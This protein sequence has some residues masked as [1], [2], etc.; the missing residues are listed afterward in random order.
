MR[1]LISILVGF[2]MSFAVLLPMQLGVK[3]AKAE[4]TATPIDM[5]LLA[6]GSNALGE[7]VHNDELTETYENVG[8]ATGATAFA[9]FKWSVQAGYG[10]TDTQVGPEYGMAQALNENG[11][12]SF[13][14]KSAASGSS[15]YDMNDKGN[16]FPR[17]IWDAGHDPITDN[18]T[19]GYEY[20]TF[21][22]GFETVYN[23]LVDNGYAPEVKGMVWMQGE[24]DLAMPKLYEELMKIFITDVRE[25]LTKITG[26]E[27]LT[28]MPFIIGKLPAAE[29]DVAAVA[30]NEMQDRVVAAMEKVFTVETADL[31]STSSAQ[32]FDAKG[33]ETLG[34]RFGEKVWEYAKRSHVTVEAENGSVS[35]D[36]DE[37]NLI[38]TLTPDKNNK[39][40]SLVINGVDRTADVV[41]DQLI[42]KNEG[43]N[44]Q[45][46][47]T[48]VE[49]AKYYV[50][51]DNIGEY[52]AT[53][54]SKAQYC[55]EGKVLKVKIEIPEEYEILSVKFNDTEMEYNEASGCYE[56]IP[57]AHGHV[58]VSVQEPVANDSTEAEAYGGHFV[59][60]EGETSS[61]NP[62]VSSISIS[63][64]ALLTLAGAA[65]AVFKR[66]H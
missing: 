4:E 12:Q 9:D 31:V 41:D 63:S 44:V 32:Q 38:F 18:K 30:F 65:Y 33:M 25:D 46:E 27:R 22:S 3:E 7:S 13:L 39:L 37:D 11:K 53:Y 43:G 47:A 55:Y 1:K 16:W 15:L 66:K 40:Q 64:V 8:Y 17:S 10:A 51:Y 60:D 21:I 26:D 34:V 45:V 29:D 24:N 36:Y 35:H 23:A 58:S 50:S 49:L 6:G 42:M 14:F 59:D 52:E 19:T 5:Y 61:Y 20:A 56:I 54:R 57:T 62:I 28:E 2:C 48:F